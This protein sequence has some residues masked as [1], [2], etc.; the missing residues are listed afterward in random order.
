MSNRIWARARIGFAVLALGAALALSLALVSPAWAAEED[1][2]DLVSG[3][4]PAAPQPEAAA[5]KPGLAVRYHKGKYNT[6]EEMLAIIGSKPGVK[7][8]PIAMLNFDDDVGGNVM[9][10]K[11]PMM[12]G[13][14]I[15]GFIKFPAAGTYI[16]KV[17]S[18]DGIDIKIGGKVV[19]ADH[20]KHGDF[21]SDGLPV[22]I[23]AP[24]WYPVAIQYFQ[25]KG[26]Y[27]LEMHWKK[28]GGKDGYAFV[29]AA[30]FAHTGD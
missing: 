14:M 23:D 21:M 10:S 28:Q 22:K 25:K 13:A 6:I 26:T 27:A 11:A 1:L 15:T 3:L 29:P 8:A 24:G 20:E 7:G 12:M 17:K 19:F 16:F 18:N 4:K 5:L 2:E 30:N 9:T